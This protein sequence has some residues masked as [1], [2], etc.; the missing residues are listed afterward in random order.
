MNK[1]ITVKFKYNRAVP[2]WWPW[3]FRYI[4]KTFR[5][6]LIVN[7]E[8]ILACLS[9]WIVCTP[10]VI[11]NAHHLLV[12]L[13]AHQ[14]TA[15]WFKLLGLVWNAVYVLLFVRISTLQLRNHTIKSQERNHILFAEY[16]SVPIRDDIRSSWRLV[17]EECLN[18][19]PIT[20][21]G[22]NT[23]SQQTC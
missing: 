21:W 2:I 13:S 20:C 6:T 23:S 22:D 4:W 19:K 3:E 12:E 7:T 15:D 18:Q 5:R 11:L 9:S 17:E 10:A 8:L 14:A 1:W 16:I